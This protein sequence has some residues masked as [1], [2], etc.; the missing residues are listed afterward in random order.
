M[1]THKRLSG[2]RE[3]WEHDKTDSESH[4][5]MPKC[6]SSGGCRRKGHSRRSTIPVRRSVRECFL[7]LH[8]L[9]R[10]ALAK[11]NG[12]YKNLIPKCKRRIKRQRA[13]RIFAL[14]YAQRSGI[15]LRESKLSVHR[16]LPE[17]REAALGMQSGLHV[18]SYMESPMIFVD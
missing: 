18:R 15:E 11:F 17:M 4:Q 13:K 6:A 14:Q 7:I 5:N 3:I 9:R 8:P 16:E 12:C 10:K 1:K 2:A